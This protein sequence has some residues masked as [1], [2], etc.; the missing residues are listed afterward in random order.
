MYF[1]H[2]MFDY[3]L[4]IIIISYMK[5]ILA[6]LFLI[7][8]LSSPVFA[9]KDNDEESS[10]S[11]GDY[12]N[13]GS[14]FDDPFAGQK[15]YTDE[16]FQK[17]LE[18]KKAKMKKYKKKKVKGDSVTKEDEKSHID[19]TGER[20]II[21]SLPINLINGDGTVIMAGYYKIIGEN[22]EGKTYLNFYQ[23]HTLVAKVPAIKTRY[24]FDEPEVNFVKIRPYDS[25]RVK[26]IFG[27]LDFNA[28]S[29][30]RILKN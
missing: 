30:L 29:F 1:S 13:S 22:D 11:M 16:D 3:F 4:K 5:K 28:Y 6:F 19:E 10:N 24:D 27:S 17:A 26:L 15:Q 12:L 25:E 23:A 14:I 21:L 20:C 7:M 18:E 8:F 2:F 9:A